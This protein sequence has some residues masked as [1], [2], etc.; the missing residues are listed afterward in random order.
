[1]KVSIHLSIDLPIDC[2]FPPIVFKSILALL[3]RIFA[4]GLFEFEEE[5]GSNLEVYRR[6]R[7]R[8]TG[9]RTNDSNQPFVCVKSALHIVLVSSAPKLQFSLDH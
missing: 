4:L 5:F 1:M 8:I 7:P 6:K 2:S 3:I 9:A